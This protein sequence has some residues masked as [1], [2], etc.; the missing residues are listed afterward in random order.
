MSQWRVYEQI[1]DNAVDMFWGEPVELHPMQ[2]G[3]VA[4]DIQPDP[5]RPIIKATAVFERPGARIVGEGGDAYARSGA[6]QVSQEVWI[7]IQDSQ[8]GGNIFAWQQHDRIYLPE[9]DQWFEINYINPSATGRP[10]MHL[11]IVQSD[12]E[13]VG[14]PSAPMMLKAHEPIPAPDKPRLRKVKRK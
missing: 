7:S 2:A 10:D 4:G 5:S 3:G 12:A 13:N 8:I 9:R 6:K 11:L 1:V 14:P